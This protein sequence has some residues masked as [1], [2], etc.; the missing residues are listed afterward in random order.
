MF[1]IMFKTE[2]FNFKDAMAVS[3]RSE[4]FTSYMLTIFTQ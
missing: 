3:L 4:L 2:T 1:H